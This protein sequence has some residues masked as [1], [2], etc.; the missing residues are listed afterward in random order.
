[1]TD[2]QTRSATR[3]GVSSQSQRETTADQADELRLESPAD[4]YDTDEAG[5]GLDQRIE[6]ARR[7]RNALKQDT[8][9]RLENEIAELASSHTEQG[10]NPQEER[11]A[12]VATPDSNKRTADTDIHT[13]RQ[14][15][16]KVRELK[17]YSGKNLR[18]LMEWRR[19][20]ETLFR[21][22]PDG[23]RTDEAK[24]THTMQYLEGEPREAWY[25]H[26]DRIGEGNTTWLEYIE[27]LKNLIDDPVGRTIA[28]A[29]QYH[30]AHQGT[31]Q[32]TYAFEAYL[33]SLEN[34][35]PRL[36]DEQRAQ[37]LLMRVRPEI[38]RGVMSYRDLPVTR[39]GMAAL[40]SKVEKT[41]GR[42]GSTLPGGN[43][44]Q[45]QASNTGRENHRGRPGPHNGRPSGRRSQSPRKDEG[46]ERKGR[47]ATQADKCHNCGRPGHFARYCKA[48]SN[49]NREPVDTS[50]VLSGK[51]SARK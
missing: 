51:G 27:F 19:A 23:Y 10:A 47:K 44:S 18:E 3:H 36:S 11:N 12:A 13:H 50:A 7:R 37:A 30:T 39:S 20:A 29:E 35:L 2:R 1:M 46:G 4:N 22:R 14:K 26:E 41:L 49:P 38:R 43:R 17:T 45:N 32:A 15:L 28:T 6:E 40:C 42:G 48:P 24:I 5:T 21:L 31:H 16:L 8:L 25:S 34:Q 33:S 9:R